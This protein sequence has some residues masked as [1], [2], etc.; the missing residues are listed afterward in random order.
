MCLSNNVR[1]TLTLEND[2]YRIVKNLADA[3]Q[4][5]LGNAVGELVLKAVCEKPSYT[6]SD[7]PVF[8]VSEKSN[9]FGLT[10]VQLAEDL[11]G[12]Q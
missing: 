6:Y 5:S 4:I 11:R 1:T 8:T 10:E 9:F 12:T 2:V 7:L 3:K